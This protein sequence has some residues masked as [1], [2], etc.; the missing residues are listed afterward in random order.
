MSDPLGRL[1]D[2]EGREVAHM[3]SS[4]TL[5]VSLEDLRGRHVVLAAGGL[6]RLPRSR[7]FC[8]PDWRLS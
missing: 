6:G 2:A 5:A 8:G 1:F 4:R 7:A 3:L